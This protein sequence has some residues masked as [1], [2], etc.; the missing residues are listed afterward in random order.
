MEDKI[1]RLVLSDPV[2]TPRNVIAC[3]RNL[4]SNVF[5]SNILFLE[6]KILLHAE[7]LNVYSGQEG[8]T[9]QV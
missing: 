5:E 8:L 1:S 2:T 9:K 7:M 3:I 4:A 6:T